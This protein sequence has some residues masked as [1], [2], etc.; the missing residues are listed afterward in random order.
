MIFLLGGCGGE[1]AGRRGEK[2]A[3]FNVFPE[4]SKEGYFAKCPEKGQIEYRVNDLA[5]GNSRKRKT[6]SDNFGAK[7]SQGSREPS[8]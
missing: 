3:G 2:R 5:S 4:K 8:L 1:E 7:V 6:A